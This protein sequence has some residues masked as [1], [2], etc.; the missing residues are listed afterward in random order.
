MTVVTQNSDISWPQP[1]DSQELHHGQGAKSAADSDEWDLDN[2]YAGNG[3]HPIVPVRRARHLLETPIGTKR[4]KSGTSGHTL[5]SQIAIVHR[6][7]FHL[8]L[9]HQFQSIAVAGD[10]SA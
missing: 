3:Q 6:D 1:R 7:V 5:G 4:D 10:F 8:M 2:P 9:R